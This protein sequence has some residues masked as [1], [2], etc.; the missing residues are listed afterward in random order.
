MS[1]FRNYFG[2]SKTAKSL[3]TMVLILFCFAAGKIFERSKKLINIFFSFQM[4]TQTDFLLFFD[5]HEIF[6]NFSVNSMSHFNS[7]LPLIKLN[8]LDNPKK[9]ERIEQLSKIC[10]VPYTFL[11]SELKTLIE[12]FR[13]RKNI[14]FPINVS[15]LCEK[16]RTVSSS[17]S[18]CESLGTL[19]RKTDSNETRSTDNDD[20]IIFSLSPEENNHLEHEESVILL[21]ESGFSHKLI[22]L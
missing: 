2:L 13:A 7:F 10:K 11:I 22:L 19:K 21:S 16:W 14:Q 3:K 9:C 17:K 4:E 1:K 20:P 18:F 5:S 6:A 8:A 15:K 12:D